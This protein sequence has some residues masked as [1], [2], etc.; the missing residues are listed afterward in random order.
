MIRRSSM[1]DIVEDVRSKCSEFGAVHHV[2]IPRDGPAR[3]QVFV[4]FGSASEAATAAQDLA[5]R[6]FGGNRVAAEYFDESS[7][8]A[9]ALA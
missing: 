6:L 4:Q 2:A 8:D 1:A 5:G 3:G 9:G 7:F